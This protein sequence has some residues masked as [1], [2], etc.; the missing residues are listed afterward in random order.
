MARTLA[1]KGAQGFLIVSANMRPYEDDHV[2]T[3][4]VCSKENRLPS[5]Y[6]NRVGSESEY[7][8]CGLSMIVDHDGNVLH[9]MDESSER[10]VTVPLAMNAQAMDAVD[11]LS[12]RK[13]ALYL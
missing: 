9:A 4:R 13:P 11:M 7:E 3:V 6:C 10:S 8:F 5:A 1:L 2:F 12:Q